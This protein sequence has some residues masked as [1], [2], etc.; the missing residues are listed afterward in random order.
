MTSAQ[1]P[2]ATAPR[3]HGD[4]A[5]VPGKS[6]CAGV[7]KIYK[8]SSNK[9][10]LG[11]SPSAIEAFRREADHLAFYPDGSAQAL[12]AAIAAQLRSRRRAHHMRQ[13]FGRT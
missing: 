7:E 6:R 2:S 13:W 4:Q 5:Y 9:S 1:S 3:N 12:R 10:P 8:L 11:P